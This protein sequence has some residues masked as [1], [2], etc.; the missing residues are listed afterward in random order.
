MVHLNTPP[1]VTSSPKM[2]VTEDFGG[3]DGWK[4]ATTE[5]IA[6]GGRRVPLRSTLSVVRQILS[7][8]KIPAASHKLDKQRDGTPDDGL[9]LCK[10]VLS[11]RGVKNARLTAPSCSEQRNPRRARLTRRRQDVRLPPS[12]LTHHASSGTTWT[13]YLPTVTPRTLLAN[14]P[15][16]VIDASIAPLLCTL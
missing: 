7:A 3:R 11:S 6:A 2:T 12:A 14:E 4:M 13:F 16:I 1:N 15:A 8:V 10:L 5:V 9:R